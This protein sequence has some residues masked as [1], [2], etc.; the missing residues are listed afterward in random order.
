MATGYHLRAKQKTSTAIPPLGELAA[1]VD[2]ATLA[3]LNIHEKCSLAPRAPKLEVFRPCLWS[4]YLVSLAFAN[5]ADR[6]SI[7]YN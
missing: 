6:Q 4:D 5:R 1:L 7:F 3:E 2:Q